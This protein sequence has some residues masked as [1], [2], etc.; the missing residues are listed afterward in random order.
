MELNYEYLLS[1]SNGNIKRVLR[2]EFILNGFSGGFGVDLNFYGGI[3]VD[4]NSQ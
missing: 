1:I 2:Q 4:F 3:D